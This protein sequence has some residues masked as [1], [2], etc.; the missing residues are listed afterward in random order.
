MN[1]SEIIETIKKLVE[2]RIK[3]AINKLA[4]DLSTIVTRVVVLVLML[5][6]SLLV[7]LF[8]SVALA[9]FL[10]QQMNSVYLGFLTVG[11]GYVLILLILYLSRNSQ[12]LQQMLK[13]R[14]TRFIFLFKHK[15]SQ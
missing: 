13:S 8:L 7:L 14:L 12:S 6:V 4:D 15:G 10:G 5:M 2:I 3:I 11:V 9:F 1:L